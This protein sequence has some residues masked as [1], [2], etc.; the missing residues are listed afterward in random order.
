MNNASFDVWISV[1]NYDPLLCL[2]FR[3]INQ[4]VY[5]RPADNHVHPLQHPELW[6]P[7]DGAALRETGAGLGVSLHKTTAVY[8][9]SVE[10][11][12]FREGSFFA[13]YY[14]FLIERHISTQRTLSL[15]WVKRMDHAKKELCIVLQPPEIFLQ[16]PSSPL[17]WACIVHATR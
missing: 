5:S 11:S 17:Q 7:K 15:K 10:Y 2:S 14:F 9:L 3:T 6:R 13:Y 4:N 12:I 16:S 8:S 1:Y